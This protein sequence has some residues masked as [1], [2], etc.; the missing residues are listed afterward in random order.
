MGIYGN[1]LRLLTEIKGSKSKAEELSQIYN[2]MDRMLKIFLNKIDLSFFTLKKIYDIGSKSKNIIKD[3]SKMRDIGREGNEKIKN[4]HKELY[5]NVPNPRAFWE[6]I[7]R[8]SGRFIN[9]YGDL[10][11]EE[12]KK[13]QSKI[14][15]YRVK[16]NKKLEELEKLRN[17]LI[18]I[19]DKYENAGGVRKEM[20]SLIGS[21]F[22]T[23]VG[24][25]QITID[26][27]K[28][29]NGYLKLEKTHSLTFKILSKIP[30]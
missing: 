20:D 19:L 29:I 7:K 4:K 13:F 10:S 18:E 6:E 14:E 21:W 27:I 16:C 15:D 17:P 28:A 5:E 22:N 30:F 26:N 8:E 3:M 25:T 11:I 12:K 1:D 2:Q 9:T 24:E 23:V